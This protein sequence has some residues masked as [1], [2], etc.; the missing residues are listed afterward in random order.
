MATPEQGTI[1]FMDD[2]GRYLIQMG[3]GSYA[4]AA[5]TG[6][7]KLPPGARV[8]LMRGRGNELATLLDPAA[9]ES[10]PGKSA[11][12]RNSEDWDVDYPK[13]KVF[14][15]AVGKDRPDANFYAFFANGATLTS[16]PGPPTG[17][18]EKATWSDKPTAGYL[19]QLATRFNVYTLKY[20]EPGKPPVPPLPPPA[21]L[22]PGPLPQPPSPG[23][24]FLGY[25]L[26]FAKVSLTASGGPDNQNGFA[27]SIPNGTIVSNVLRCAPGAPPPQIA[28]DPQGQRYLFA[29][30]YYE[31]NA[32]D[33]EPITGQSAVIR[34]SVQ[35]QTNLGLTTYRV[36]MDAV[37]FSNGEQ[38]NQRTGSKSLRALQHKDNF[39]F[40]ITVGT[41]GSVAPE[42]APPAGLPGPIDPPAPLP[43]GA[44][45]P[46]NS[47]GEPAR[48]GDK[49]KK[50]G[51]VVVAE[52]TQPREIAELQVSGKVLKAYHKL[53][54]HLRI[55]A[56]QVLAA[57]KDKLL[58]WLKVPANVETVGGAQLTALAF[59]QGGIASAQLL[60]DN[61]AKLSPQLTRQDRKETLKWPVGSQRFAKGDCLV[62]CV[63][64]GGCNFPELDGTTW[65]IDKI[66]YRKLAS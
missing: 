13:G 30:G 29:P 33:S 1:V 36:D 44:P 38:Y 27:V 61:S 35:F 42:W 59:Q 4:R 6:S 62:V 41:N 32:I 9:T 19:R 57:D 49:A 14:N 65:Q 25:R 26:T 34:G 56:L 45:Q 15:E 28:A 55:V 51:A 60:A 12:Q 22:P 47:P 7:G 52:L 3:D 8:Q 2:S 66:V 40:R 23:S 43:P 64:S 21:P 11:P 37:P 39:N 53:N 20:D 50:C 54:N 46:P 5:K 48:G 18:A 31:Y 58:A 16:V 10:Q 63:V 24:S 17:K